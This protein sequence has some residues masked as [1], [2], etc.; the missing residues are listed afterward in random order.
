MTIAERPEVELDPADGGASYEELY[1]Q[2]PCGF[3]SLS[4]DGTIVRVNQTLLDWT[5]HERSALLGAS[6]RTL[7][8]PG[9]QIFYETRFVP[10]LGLEGRAREV[11]FELRRADG[12]SLHVLT[13]SD[14]VGTDDQAQ[15]RM[16]V[17][18]STQRHTYERDLVDARRR[19]EASEARVRVLQDA[20]SVFAGCVTVDD[21]AEAL[22]QIAR[23]A[24]AAT[25][26]SVML[27]H[28]S[29]QLYIAAGTHP[30]LPF[31]P[32]NTLE[33]GSCFRASRRPMRFVPTSDSRCARRESRQSQRPPS[34]VRAGCSACCTARLGG[35]GS[36]T[37]HSCSSTRH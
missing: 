22:V 5:G 29:G 20:T 35:P 34:R 7:L 13:N 23:D 2:A 4:L 24:F 28:E 21:V 17:F 30:L 32:A 37:L 10:V 31:L 33:R 19:A 12:S 27:M 11:A 15:V 16:A 26:A 18:D 3:L 14:V 1:E 6:I 9:S 25:E 36:S 8:A